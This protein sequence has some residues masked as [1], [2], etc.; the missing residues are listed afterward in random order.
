MNLRSNASS[1]RRF[2]FRAR[3]KSKLNKLG[4]H[5]DAGDAEPAGGLGLVAVGEIN[6]LPE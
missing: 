1:P 4:F 3:M 2:V 5:G 6:G